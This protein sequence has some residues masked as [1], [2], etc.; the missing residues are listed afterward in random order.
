MLRVTDDGPGLAAG[1]R[2][3]AFE[4]FYR[5]D[6]SRSSKGHGLGLALVRA[7][8]K[9]HAIDISLGDA[10]PGLA[11]DLRFAHGHE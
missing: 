11:V 8:A 9:L 6:R 5:A 3:R 2:E 4:R 7:I 10:A 1:D